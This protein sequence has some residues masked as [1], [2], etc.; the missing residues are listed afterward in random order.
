MPARPL[1]EFWIRQSQ[2]ATIRAR[3]LAE[4]QPLPQ[5]GYRQLLRFFV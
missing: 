4:I 2:S 1:V 5:R 3:V